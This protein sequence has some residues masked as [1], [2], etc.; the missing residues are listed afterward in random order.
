MV[1]SLQ[2]MCVK[3]TDLTDRVNLFE[4][5][6]L[7]N[8]KLR[9]QVTKFFE[10]LLHRPPAL[11]DLRLGHKILLWRLWLRTE[12]LLGR[13]SVIDV[14]VNSL[15]VYH[16]SLSALL[17]LHCLLAFGLLLEVWL[18]W[19]DGHLH[20]LRLCDDVSSKYIFETITNDIHHVTEGLVGKAG[21]S[22]LS[23]DAWA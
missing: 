16:L 18:S 11:L 6:H 15:N 14:D 17:R 22:H 9:Q 12:L 4:L 2:G 23:L 5:G 20:R 21:L 3:S 10:G 19:V 8:L 13:R 1:T 7:L